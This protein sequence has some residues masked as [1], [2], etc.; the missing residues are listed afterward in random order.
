MRSELEVALEYDELEPQAARV[1]GSV[2]QEVERMSRTVENLLTLARFDEGRLELLRRPFELR[3]VLDDVVAELRPIAGDNDV[4]IA[5]A[6]DGAVVTADR[7]R[8]RQV[9]ANLVDNA[10]K[11][12]AAGGEVRI[13]TWRRNGEVGISV[14]DTGSGIPASALPHVFDRFYR[15]DGSRGSARGGS[16]LGLAI[17]EQIVAAHGGRIWAES[18]EGHGSTFSLI[19][20]S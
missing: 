8:V 5:V 14:A 1:L 20:L 18:E 13:A 16:G 12:S 11:H 2:R 3:E 17:S 6:G 10:V 19:L 9:V 7:D 4:T 15:V